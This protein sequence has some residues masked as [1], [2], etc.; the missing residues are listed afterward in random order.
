MDGNSKG[1]ATGGGVMYP[2]GKIRR[3]GEDFYQ[4]RL[5]IFL[6]AKEYDLRRE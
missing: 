4:F 2:L 6:R 5:T 3:G 1:V